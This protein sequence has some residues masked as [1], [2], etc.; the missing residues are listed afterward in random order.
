MAPRGLGM[1]AQGGQGG[2]RAS[3]NPEWASYYV[4]YKALKQILGQLTPLGEEQTEGGAQL[5]GLFLSSLLLQLQKVN[6]FYVVKAQELA[7]HLERI[8]PLINQGV[9]FGALV[10]DQ[11]PMPSVP[12]LV[13]HKLVQSPRVYP[14]APTVRVAIQVREACTRA[15]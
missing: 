2:P 7:Q 13:L 3:E 11:Q 10:S 1:V 12:R 15:V 9:V 6:A 5:E 4:D 14:N 8:M